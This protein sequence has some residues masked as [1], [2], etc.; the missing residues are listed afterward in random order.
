N[1]FLTASRASKEFLEGNDLKKRNILESLCW[2]LS[3][4][5]KN[6]HTVSLKSPFDIMAKASKNDGLCT[7]LGG[8]ESNQ[9]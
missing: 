3:L 9:D 7:K 1:A 8:L 6:I 4:K 5:E 2:N